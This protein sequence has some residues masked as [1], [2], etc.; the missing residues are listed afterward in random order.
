MEKLPDELLYFLTSLLSTHDITRLIRVSKRFHQLATPRIWRIIELHSKNRHLSRDIN[1]PAPD[2]PNSER[3]YFYSGRSY[4]HTISAD[5]FKTLDTIRKEDEHRFKL[6]A[7][8]VR[9]LCCEVTTSWDMFPYFINLE[10]LDLSCDS[11]VSHDFPVLIESETLPLPNLRF[12]SLFGY[13]PREFARWA[14][15]AGPTLERIELGMLDRPISGTIAYERSNYPLPEDKVL[16]SDGDPESSNEDSDYGSLD[17]E[18]V[19]PRPLGSFMP[20]SESTRNAVF[21]L[22]KHLYLSQPSLCDYTD[23]VR[24]YGWSSRAEAACLA[25]WKEL[26]LASSSTL[27]VLVLEQRPCAEDIERDSYSAAEFVLSNKAG[28][29][30]EKLVEMILECPST[31]SSFPHLKKVYL[32]GIAVGTQDGCSISRIPRDTTPGSKLMWFLQERGV[33]CEARIGRWTV[34]EEANGELC[35][36][37]GNAVKDNDGSGR[38]HR[39]LIATTDPEITEVDS[40]QQP[41]PEDDDEDEYD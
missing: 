40:P 34:F 35:W 27:E 13:I 41:R 2:T 36:Y 24:E 23:S 19:C 12:V 7:A 39:R 37:H 30:S 32:W 11:Y 16:N 6:L 29:G 31:E 17:A 22:L 1:Y 38:G 18:G 33:A 25:D 4:D 20:D 8:R 21:P 15:R 14:L 5:F 3:P 28:V 26:L 10:T 9:G